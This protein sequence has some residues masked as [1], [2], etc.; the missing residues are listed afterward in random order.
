MIATTGS[1]WIGG[2]QLASSCRKGSTRIGI[3][4]GRQDCGNTSHSRKP[5]RTHETEELGTDREVSKEVLR[6]WRRCR[7]VRKL[8]PNGHRSR[9]GGLEANGVGVL[10]DQWMPSKMIQVLEIKEAVQLGAWTCR[11]DE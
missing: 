9:K 3:E 2:Y 6:G 1:Q 8:A 11:V 7:K 4:A 10:A 5:M